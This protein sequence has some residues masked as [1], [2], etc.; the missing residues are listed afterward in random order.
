MEQVPSRPRA[1]VLFL[2]LAALWISTGEVWAGTLGPSSPFHPYIVQGMEEVFSGRFDEALKVT[3]RM[4]A[5]DPESPVG[6]FYRG[7]TYWWMFLIDPDNKT[8]G[9]KVE[10][11]LERAVQKGKKRLDAD[12]NDVEALFYL[13]GAYGFRARYRIVEARWWGAAWDGRKAKGFLEKVA[14]L[15]PEWVDTN[16]GL[17]MYNYYVD[18][19]PKY[20]QVLRIVAFIPAGDREKGLAQLRR[21]MREGIYTRSEARFFLLDIM[22]DHEKD[23]VRALQL[24]RELAGEYP[25]NPFFRLLEVVIHVNRLGRYS[26]AIRLSEGLLAEL[27]NSPFMFADD[28]AVRAQYY[29]GKAHFFRGNSPAALNAFETL[30]AGDPERPQ[31]VIAWANMRLGQVYDMEGRREEALARYRRVLKM[32]EYGETHDAARR[33]IK[34]PFGE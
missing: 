33:W 12:P 22:K 32:R 14:A 18:V 6:H 30:L 11:N 15:E 7:A 26:E 8:V 9:T 24:V 23:Y 28:V 3:E 5:L 25:E 29:L 31:W 27:E 1:L 13:G 20:F 21:A 16:L 4:I 34:K 2:L 17:G 10:E 19:L